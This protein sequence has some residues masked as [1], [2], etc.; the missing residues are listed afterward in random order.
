T[1]NTTTQQLNDIIESIDDCKGTSNTT[2]QQLNDIRE[3]IDDCKGTSNKTT[4]KLDELLENME[5]MGQNRMEADN[6][7]M[8]SVKMLSNEVESDGSWAWLG[9]QGDGSKFV[10]A[11]G[12]RGLDNASPLWYPGKPGSNV[13]ADRCLMML[14]TGS[15][16]GDHPTTPYWP[17]P[18]SDTNF[19]LCEVK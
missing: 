4:Q 17:Q 19:A 7:T 8:T 9:A 3:S 2:K 5:V 10:Y 18:C 6:G 11:H 15:Y 12:G 16:F 14:A 1:S 13:D